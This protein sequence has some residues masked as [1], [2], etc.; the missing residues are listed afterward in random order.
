MMFKLDSQLTLTPLNKSR[1]NHVGMEEVIFSVREV[2][3]AKKTN[4]D[5]Q[6]THSNEGENDGSLQ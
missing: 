2:K 3:N 5:E 4:A 6:K 1:K